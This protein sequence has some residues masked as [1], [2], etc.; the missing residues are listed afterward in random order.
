V[1]VSAAFFPV[2]INEVS[3]SYVPRVGAAAAL[4]NSGHAETRGSAREGA[5]LSVCAS[6]FGVTKPASLFFGNCR[7]T[8]VVSERSRVVTTASRNGA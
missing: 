7:E 1:G 3:Y 8:R 5:N 2:A 4:L 6:E